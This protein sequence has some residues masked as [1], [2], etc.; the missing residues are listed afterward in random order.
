VHPFKDVCCASLPAHA[1][2]QLAGLRTVTG[3]EA[4]VQ[5]D[6]AWVRWQAGDLETL[7]IIWPADS[8]RLFQERDGLWF[9]FG[10]HLPTLDVP[11]K[12][13]QPLHRVLIPTNPTRK[14]G[15]DKEDHATLPH[16]SEK[17]PLTLIADDQPQ[18]TTALRC[19]IASLA[20][21]SDTA[22]TSR[23]ADLQAACKGNRV[24]LRGRRLPM[25]P[26]SRRYWGDSV[27]I[28]LGFRTAPWL[29]EAD[30]RRLVEARDNELVVV[31]ERSIEIVRQTAF[32]PLKRASVRRAVM[33]P[34]P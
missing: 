32:A 18:P 15:T 5:H 24:L 31:E 16:T 21:W 14:R 23:L 9:E 10:K 25:L 8:V 20:Q 30:V 12:G 29:P 3:V 19:D 28:P 13:Y 11:L 26:N 1:L 22:P 33:E 2:P 34:R 7:R 6:Q 27:L 17:V 4:L